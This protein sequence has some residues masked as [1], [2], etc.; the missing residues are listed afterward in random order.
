M[1][2]LVINVPGNRVGEPTFISADEIAKTGVAKGFVISGNDE[3]Q[4]TAGC[5]VILVDNYYKTKR[6]ECRLVE[7]KPTETADN[8]WQRYSVY[9]KDAIRKPYKYERAN[10]WGTS[11]IEV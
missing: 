5:V 4:L 1:K 9:L 2:A 6:Y 11:V 8:G 7:L 10:R 3:S